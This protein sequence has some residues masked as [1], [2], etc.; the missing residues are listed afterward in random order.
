MTAKEMYDEI[1]TLLGTIAK[2]LEVPE[3][4]VAKAVEDGGVVIEM[5]V[6]DNGR[7]YV[8]A[9]RDGRAARIYDGAILYEDQAPPREGGCSCGH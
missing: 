1:A 3:D 4:Q 7:R 2:A 8:R 6:D 9:S 5:G